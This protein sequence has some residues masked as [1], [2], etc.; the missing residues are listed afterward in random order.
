MKILVFGHKLHVG[1]AQVNAIELAAALRDH[2]GFN[3]AY[4]ATPGPM[5]SLVKERDLRYVPA[6]ETTYH[7]SLARM[8]AL[9]RLVRQESPDLVHSW[10][11]FQCIDAY[12]SVHIGMGVPMIVTDMMMEL[13]RVLPRELP[14]TYGTPALV[15]AAR[16]AGHRR[17]DL[18]LP[19]VD[20]H[21]NAPDVVDSLSFRARYGIGNEEI[22][23]TMVSRLDTRMKAEGLSRTIDVVQKCGK[24]LPLRCV[25]VGGGPARAALEAQA[26][27]VN[28]TLQRTAVTFTGPLL[29]PRPAYA[30]ADIVLGM[31]GSALRGMAFG[32]PVII[33]GENGFSAPL[34]PETA[35]A[36]HYA[37][38][39]GSG[40]GDPANA[41]LA[42]EV[43]LLAE[44]PASLPALGLYSRQFVTRHYALEAVSARFARFCQ[45]ALSDLPV[46]YA[47][48][49]DGLR[50]AAVYVRET[51]FL[52]R[53]LPE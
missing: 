1:G 50:T 23:L 41:R 34:T 9:R 25:I 27:G 44:H 14:T 20:I 13:D 30:A 52:F 22:V 45:S 7:P 24:D 37:G 2:H 48:V 21:S 26:A 31:G 40:S 5:L 29:D 8:K 16:Q 47:G 19:A 33:V 43:R 32:K 4:C 49:L 46:S 6:P 42:R 38:M 18:L 51:K 36:I 10:D 3:V 53:W 35:D 11:W 17:L 12:Y 39:Y 28:E 15:D